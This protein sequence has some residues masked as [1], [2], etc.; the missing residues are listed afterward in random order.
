[1][2]NSSHTAIAKH[3]SSFYKAVS[4]AANEVPVHTADDE[5][6]NNHDD[7]DEEVPITIPTGKIYINYQEI[8][9]LRGCNKILQEATWVELLNQACINF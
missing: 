9:A 3:V 8:F 1:M 6:A 7:D 2:P 4:E 5:A